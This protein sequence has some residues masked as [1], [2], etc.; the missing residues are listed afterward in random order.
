[1]QRAD[2]LSG[3]FLFILA[4][5]ICVGAWRLDVGIPHAPAPGFFPFISGSALGIFSLFI[6]ISGRKK[7]GRHKTFWLPNADKKGILLAFGV[8][9]FYALFLEFLGFLL[10]NIIFFFLISRFVAHRGWG[11]TIAYTIMCSAGVQL[12]FN[13]LFNT[14]LPAGI[15][16]QITF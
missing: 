3:L 4:I 6:W 5:F 8:L 10:T 14:P 9:I 7:G 12:V 2:F 15:F 13:A 1:M 11:I 16:P